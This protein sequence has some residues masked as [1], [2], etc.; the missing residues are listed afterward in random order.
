VKSNDPLQLPL[1]SI[2]AASP[3]PPHLDFPLQ[4]FTGG[5]AY[6]LRRRPGTWGGRQTL[7]SLRLHGMR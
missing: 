4:P 7:R 5:T 1:N 2:L 3:V 6:E